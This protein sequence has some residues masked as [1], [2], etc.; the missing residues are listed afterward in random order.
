M[1][2][3]GHE[4]IV[5][6]GGYGLLYERLREVG[7]ETIHIHNL[8]RDVDIL[9]ELKVIKSLYRIIQTERPDIIHLNSSKIGAIGSILGRLLRVEKIIF[10]AHGFPFRED[11]N[12]LAKLII[13]FIS[14]LTIIFS[15]KTICVSHCDLNAVKN[16]LGARNKVVMIHNGVQV[17]SSKSQDSRFKS[18]EEDKIKSSRLKIQEEIQSTN[19]NSKQNKIIQIVSIG[20]LTK[21]KGFIYALQ[22][23]NLLKNRT[24]NFCY[25]IVSFGGEERRKL[26]KIILDLNLSEY[27]DLLISNN[28]HQEYLEKSDIYFLPSIKEGLPYVLLEAGLSGLPILAS[29]TGGV[30]EIVQDEVDG[31]LIPAKDVDMA[32]KELFKLIQNEKLRDNFGEKIQAK[33]IRDFGIEQMLT[34][35]ENVYF[36]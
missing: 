11:R 10:T 8:E 24:Q 15:T 14:W 30:R 12:I 13:K 21:N 32:E 28:N 34:K 19:L 18:Q 4:V 6:H 20:E 5:A 35:T 26:E 7:I 3:L 2:K 16:W 29:D 27:V 25:S 36:G 1:Q 9:K 33:I 31:L 23:I 22:T 17:A